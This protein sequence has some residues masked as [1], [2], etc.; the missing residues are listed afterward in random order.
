MTAI[1]AGTDLPRWR[2]ESAG[3][4]PLRVREAIPA[5]VDHHDRFE[6]MTDEAMPQP[7]DRGAHGGHANTCCNRIE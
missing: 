3:R 1:T 6:A 5:D 2:E 4:T 7:S